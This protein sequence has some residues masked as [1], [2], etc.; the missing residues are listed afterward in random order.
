MKF[1]D[2]GTITIRAEWKDFTGDKNELT[3]AVEDTG[4]GIREDMLN[5]IFEAFRQQD[6]HDTKKYGG[7]GLGLAISKRLVN[8]MGGTL[9]VKS[10][11]GEG[12]L[13]TISFMDVELSTTSA[14]EEVHHINPFDHYHFNPSTILIVDD[15]TSNRE[16][17]KSFLLDTEVTCHE[18]VNGKAAVELAE[19]LKPDLILMD[20]R[21]PVMDG[22][23][24]SAKIKENPETA[25]IP[26]V[27]ISAS[28]LQSD[29][30]R[31]KELEFDDF[32][33]KPVQIQDFYAILAKYLPCNVTGG[34]IK[35]TEVVNALSQSVTIPDASIPKL[36]EI[37][38]RLDN[39]FMKQWSIVKDSPNINDV[40]NFAV[41]LSDFGK[42]YLIQNLINYGSALEYT[43][44]HVE[45]DEMKSLLSFF[46]ELAE[47]IKK[48]KD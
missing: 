23:E 38:E 31:I 30:Q 6:E 43:A 16:L 4:I 32:L 22:F 34:S 5:V 14:T 13:F 26:I 9:S 18:A 11:T 40:E 1:T 35:E 10:K 17:I 20:L 46:P 37:I 8:L 21:M 28:A 25:E 33:R 44:K 48:A 47:K 19:E 41:Q 27:V 7:T 42:K 15:I 39:S 29:K 45:I 36:P 24:A 3:I 12:S 2:E